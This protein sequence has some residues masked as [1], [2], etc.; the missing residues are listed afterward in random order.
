M[1]LFL[2]VVLAGVMVLG[3]GGTAPMAQ[4]TAESG[5]HHRQGLVLYKQRQYEEALEAFQKAVE[6][7][8]SNAQALFGMGLCYKSLRQYDRAITAYEK[9]LEINPSYTKVHSALGEVWSVKGQY[10]EAE[11]SYLHAIQSDSTFVQAYERLGMLYLKQEE[12]DQAISLSGK[13]TAVAPSAKVYE[14]LG[15]ASAKKEMYEEAITAYR[16][17]VRWSPRDGELRYRL[18][19][20][21][22]RAG[23]YLEAALEAQESLELTKGGYTPALI[24]LAEAYEHQGKIAEAIEEYT[25]AAQDVNWQKYAQYKIEELRK[26]MKR[27]G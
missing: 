24:S 26:Q 11:N 10:A 3:W 9:A 16:E 27:G 2:R 13:A 4:V 22:N 20:A 15:I 1:F 23:R 5:E 17:A 25:K 18:A 19:D 21:Y 14:I 7:D 8:P 12:Y 6:L